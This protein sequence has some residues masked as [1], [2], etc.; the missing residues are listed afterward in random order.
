MTTSK[1]GFP[2]KAE[3]GEDLL[4]GLKDL[5]LK[6]T[7]NADIV[8]KYM[9]AVEKFL[10]GMTAMLGLTVSDF[11]LDKESLFDL[12]DNMLEGEYSPIVYR[13][14]KDGGKRVVFLETE[15]YDGYEMRLL[16][17]EEVQQIAG[18]AGRKGIYEEG[19]FTACGGRKFIRQS[20]KMS[21]EEIDFARIR[22]PGFLVAVEGKLS[23]VMKRWNELETESLFLKT[24]IDQ[25]I[26]LCLWLED[27]SDDKETI[28]RLINIPFNEKNEDILFLWKTLALRVAT[29]NSID[30]TH[31]IETLAREKK[32]ISGMT[33]TSQHIQQL[34]FLYQKYDLVHNFIR[35][36]GK[37]DTR[38]ANKEL[39]RKKKKEV[40]DELT[41]I[42][43]KKKLKRRQCSSCGRFLP[44]NYPYGMCSDCYE[45][46]QARRYNRYYGYYGYGDF[47]DY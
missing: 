40:S 26:D 46:M 41:A 29:E 32:R 6:L 28:Y 3:G 43:K 33:D 25:Q 17:P 30:L 16:K 36:F 44:Y 24:D 45:E 9:E 10:P 15:K 35:L 14:E 42:L 39:L 23:G 37:L 12:R 19:R 2:L 5:K 31:E 20:M 4:K 22:F 1:E 18:R 47:E 34:E 11:T 13:A 21:P 7:E 8:Q 27:H 38:D